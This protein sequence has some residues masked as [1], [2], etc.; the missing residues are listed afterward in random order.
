MSDFDMDMSIDFESVAKEIDEKTNTLLEI[1]GGKVEGN[2]KGNITKAPRVD[3]GRMRNSIA[4]VVDKEEK[5]VTIGTPVEYAVYNELGTGIYVQGG[6]QT[7]W[8]YM[9]AD[10]NLHWTRGMKGIHFL[11]NA[12]TEHLAEIAEDSENF[13]KNT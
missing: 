6:R 1:L 10:G 5:S 4:H 9:D 11:R 8:A 12:V 13:L 3:T 2:A 7:P